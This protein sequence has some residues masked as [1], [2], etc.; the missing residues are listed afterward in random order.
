MIVTKEFI[1]QYDEHHY[2]VGDEFPHADS[3]VETFKTER[4]NLL[5]SGGYIDQATAVEEV[6][7]TK[8]E[9]KERLDEQGVKYK[10]NASKD[11]LVALMNSE[12]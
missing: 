3:V 10:S 5:K 12:E 7:L 9:I 1:D 2:R 11:E 6:D 4:I 8:D